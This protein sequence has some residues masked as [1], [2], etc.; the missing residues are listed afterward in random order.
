MIIRK[1]LISNLFSYT[2]SQVSFGRYNVITGINGAGKSHILRIL[3]LITS[4]EADFILHW[5]GSRPN[6]KVKYALILQNK[7]VIW[8]RSARQNWNYRRRSEES[9]LLDKKN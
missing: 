3:N 2:L 8:H 4:C 6:Q 1:L 9:D 7:L 5:E